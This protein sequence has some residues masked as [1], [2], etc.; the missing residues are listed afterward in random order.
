MGGGRAG[1]DFDDAFVVH[2]GFALDVADPPFD[3]VQ[4]EDRDQESNADPCDGERVA[5]GQR[6]EVAEFLARSLFGYVQHWVTAHSSPDAVAR[7]VSGWR[8]VRYTTVA[9]SASTVR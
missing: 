2:P 6:P 4:D 3:A 5:P 7:I 1:R 9:I 8:L